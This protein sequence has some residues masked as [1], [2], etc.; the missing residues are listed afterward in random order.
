MIK[1]GYS[2]VEAKPKLSLKDRIEILLSVEKYAVEVSYV[3][4]AINITGQRIHRIK[5]TK[6][7]H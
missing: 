5:K 1:L 4:A 3:V 6:K 7:A 2:L